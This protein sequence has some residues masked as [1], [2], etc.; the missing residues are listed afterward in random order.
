MDIKYTNMLT[1]GLGFSSRG[2]DDTAEPGSIEKPEKAAHTP[3]IFR[4]N[5]H[6]HFLTF[7]FPVWRKIYALRALRVQLWRAKNHCRVNAG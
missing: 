1:L 5:P 3:L 4:E 6:F 2:E 7:K